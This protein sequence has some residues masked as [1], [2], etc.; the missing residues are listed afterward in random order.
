LSDLVTWAEIDLA[1]YAHNV[2]EL[3]ELCRPTTRLMAV[4]KADAYGHGAARL[5]R[6]AVA[7]GVDWFGVARLEEAVSLR[8]AG[9]KVPILILGFT[10]VGEADVLIEYDLTQ[11]VLSLP[12]AS[13]LSEHA[14]ARGKKIRSHLKI[15]TGMGRIGLVSHPRGPGSPAGLPVEGTIRDALAIARLPGL[16]L[17]GIFTHL[18]SADRA[19]NGDAGRQL[20]RFSTLV[21]H[22]EQEGLCFEL[23]HAANSAAMIRL[24]ESHLDMVRPGIATYGLRPSTQV[25]LGAI[26]LEPVLQWKSRIVQLKKVPAEFGVS[27]GTTYTTSQPTTLA[28]IPVGYA[29]GLRWH[30][31]SRGQMLVGGRRVP[32]VGRVCMD[33]VV[34]DVGE[35]PDVRVGDEVVLIGRQ[36]DEFLGADEMAEAIG[37][38]NYEVLTS[39]TPRIPRVYLD[40]VPG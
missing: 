15:D 22:L 35:I 21:E 32:I 1:A 17:E 12:L 13:A 24:P 9:V 19:G 28:T 30:L 26:G 29:D 10:S 7:S 16:E 39:I 6:P 2:A 37:T 3:K 14:V 27:Y 18:A 4:V 31:S 8:Q 25:D 40:E 5:A 20:E 38:I 36:G 11:A 23:R 34:L 33:M